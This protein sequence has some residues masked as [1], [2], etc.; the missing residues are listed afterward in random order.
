MTDPEDQTR[1]ESDLAQERDASG[2]V[3]VELPEST[4]E[5]SGIFGRAPVEN[6]PIGD[7]DAPAQPL[8]VSKPDQ[9]A[10]DQ[11]AEE[12]EDLLEHSEAVEPADNPVI[13]APRV[14]MRRKHLR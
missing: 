1:T 12:S 3:T 5:T 4:T 10:Q 8:V 6:P 13:K 9:P 11:N 7:W 14:R 2:S